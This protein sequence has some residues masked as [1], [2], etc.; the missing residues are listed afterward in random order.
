MKRSSED[1][2]TLLL[3]VPSTYSLLLDL[4]TGLVELSFPQS[5]D[6]LA[7]LDESDSLMRVFDLENGVELNLIFNF[8][9]D[10]GRDG[11]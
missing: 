5:K 11:S 3:E 2:F 6:N 7:L 1:F 8:L 10:L 4:D 9:A